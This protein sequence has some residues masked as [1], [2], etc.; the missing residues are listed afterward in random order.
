VADAAAARGRAAGLEAACQ[1]HV[2]RVTTLSA[3]LAELQQAQARPISLVHMLHVNNAGRNG[4]P[5]GLTAAVSSCHGHAHKLARCPCQD[6]R[7]TCH[8]V[9]ES[10]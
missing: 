4:A 10:V 9:T 8:R 1:A 5:G 3:K 2:A 6:G 7:S